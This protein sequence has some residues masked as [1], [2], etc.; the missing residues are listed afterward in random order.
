MIVYSDHDTR[1]LAALTIANLCQG[2][3]CILGWPLVH[4][5]NEPA[6][7][8]LA[9]II[10]AIEGHAESIAKPVDVTDTLPDLLSRWR[11]LTSDYNAAKGA[12]EEWLWA[13]RS[14]AERQIQS[15][16]PRSPAGLAALLVWVLEDST[17]NHAGQIT[18][19]HRAALTNALSVLPRI[20]PQTDERNAA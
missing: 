18:E 16:A 5:E 10:D 20:E 9:G 8:G 7:R 17:K 4:M 3:S 19:G 1:D 11:G 15:T 14:E 2:A 12:S 6:M 13:Q